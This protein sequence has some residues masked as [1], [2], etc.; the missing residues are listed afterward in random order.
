MCWPDFG[1]MVRC[2]DD[3]YELIPRHVLMKFGIVRHIFE[4]FG[5][6]VEI[7][8]PFCA[9]LMRD[10]SDWL[11][12]ADVTTYRQGLWFEAAR[13]AC[14]LDSYELFECLGLK[15]FLP[16]ITGN[17]VAMREFLSFSSEYID[18]WDEDNFHDPFK[19]L[20]PSNH[21][22]TLFPLSI[23]RRMFHSLGNRLAMRNFYL[24]FGSEHAYFSILKTEY[25]ILALAEI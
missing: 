16:R 3:D 20:D 7:R 12:G 21:V 1:Y 9:N 25:L 15:A 13:V 2:E 22:L 14:Y 23:V 8:V 4:T 10:I 19:H 18:D 24:S 17:H 11:N 6:N 5:E